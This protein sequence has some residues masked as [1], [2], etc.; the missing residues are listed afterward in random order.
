VKKRIEF[1]LFELVVIGILLFV[2]LI[3]ALPKFIDVSREA[4]IKTLNAVVQN[5]EAVNRLMYSRAVIKNVQNV[6]LQHSDVLG[7]EVIN[8]YL[9]YGELRAEPVDLMNVTISPLIILEKTKQPG[10]V[11]FYLKNYQ[12]EGCY[13]DYQQ[14]YLIN[15]L[16]PDSVSPIINRA[17]YHVNSINC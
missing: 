15:N 3:V 13:I 8:V 12:K 10:E 2:V 4:R 9:V 7:G 6:A 1:P 5:L 17:Q 16:R 14:A 11:R